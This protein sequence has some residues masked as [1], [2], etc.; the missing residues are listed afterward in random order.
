MP[1]GVSHA[2]TGPSHDVAAGRQAAECAV[3][4]APLHAPLCP[5][6]GQPNHCAASAADQLGRTAGA[7]LGAPRRAPFPAVLS[8]SVNNTCAKYEPGRF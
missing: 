5:L 1:T 6:C 8:V 7:P 3:T 4:N 2:R